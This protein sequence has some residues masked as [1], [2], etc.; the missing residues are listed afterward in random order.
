MRKQNEAVLI[1]RFCVE[2]GL[3]SRLQY[4]PSESINIERF[5]STLRH[6][7]N[8]FELIPKEELEDKFLKIVEVR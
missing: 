6:L 1:A 4:N 5:K 2:D 7:L 3:T 8:S